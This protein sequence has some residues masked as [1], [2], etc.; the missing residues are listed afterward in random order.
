[1][2]ELRLCMERMANRVFILAN[3]GERAGKIKGE[4]SLKI[5]M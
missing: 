1:M 5:I 2:A 3:L 4:N